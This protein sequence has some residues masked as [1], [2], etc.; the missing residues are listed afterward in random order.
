MGKQ[1]KNQ[2]LGFMDIFPIF[3]LFHYFWS[4]FGLAWKFR[5]QH[6]CRM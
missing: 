2:N 5:Q 6:T 4:D 1:R 3:M